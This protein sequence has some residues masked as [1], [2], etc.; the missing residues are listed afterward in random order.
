[1][2][3]NL[4]D[5]SHP[6]N[7][8]RKCD[9]D[10]FRCI[11]TLKSPLLSTELKY[12]ECNFDTG[13]HQQCKNKTYIRHIYDLHASKNCNGWSLHST[14]QKTHHL[15]WQKELYGFFSVFSLFPGINTPQENHTTVPQLN[16]YLVVVLP[17]FSMQQIHTLWQD[18]G[19]YHIWT[20]V[21]NL[22]TSY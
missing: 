21:G 14:P 16:R 10:S 4:Y 17:W 7:F 11:H 20:H 13:N 2:N 5:A 18:L 1:M 19:K 6:F 8:I 12:E 22:L 3:R 15:R 9:T